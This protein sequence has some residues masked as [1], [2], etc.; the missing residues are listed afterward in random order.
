M[1]HG[2]LN[3]RIDFAAKHCKIERLG[4]KRL[5]TVFQCLPLR[6]GVTIGGDHND[7]NIRPGGFVHGNLRLS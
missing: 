5:G 7:W 6:L 1:L 4:K 3:S 2:L